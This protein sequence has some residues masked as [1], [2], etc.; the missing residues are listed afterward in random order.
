[1]IQQMNEFVSRGE[2]FA[3]ETTFSGMDYLIR[4][5]NWK[6]SGYFIIVYYLNNAIK[7]LKYDITIWF[8]KGT[9]KD[10]F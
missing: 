6:S 7:M 2:S 10:T 3:V 1:M 5:D 8:Y 4:I 9:L